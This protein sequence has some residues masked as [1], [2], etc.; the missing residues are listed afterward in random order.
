MSLISIKNL[1]KEYG[2]NIV[3][4]R[5]NLEI[6]EGEFC[7]LVGPSGCGKS[8]FLKMVLGQE[9]PTRGKFFFNEKPFPEE[10]SVE[11]GIVFQRYSVFSHLNVL[12]NVMLGIELEKSKFLGKLFGKERKKAKQTAMEMLEAVGLSSSAYKYPEELSGGMQQRLSI[13]QSLVKKPKVLLLDEP[14][15]A[16]DPG[17]SADM[18]ALILDLWKKNNLTVIMVTHDLHEGFYLGTRL[19][20]FDKV[21]HDPEFPDRYGAKITYDIPV[22]E[23]SNTVYKEIDTTIKKR[24]KDDNRS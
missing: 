1:Y 4:E 17:I 2:D 18:H 22:G 20:V 10:P 14:F 24:G 11:R 12:E 16:L 23:T 5:L 7:T 19:L 6:E 15:G 9:T 3:L 8:T 21:K 13:A